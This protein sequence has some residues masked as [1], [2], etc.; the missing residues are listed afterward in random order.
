VRRGGP[1]VLLIRLPGQSFFQTLRRK[2]HW[3]VPHIE[4]KADTASY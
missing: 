3:A 1:T 2:L 4:Q